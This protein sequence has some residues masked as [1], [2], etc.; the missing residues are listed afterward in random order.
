M[1]VKFAINAKKVQHLAEI[2]WPIVGILSTFARVAIIYKNKQTP[3][4]F[5]LNAEYI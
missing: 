5:R 3:N 2:V 4:I 1:S